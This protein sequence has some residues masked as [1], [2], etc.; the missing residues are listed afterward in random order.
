MK[1]A[2][3]GAGPMAKIFAEKAKN[4]DIETHCF[5]WE[6]GAEAK[7]IVDFFYPISIFEKE[8]IL[9]IC[10]ELKIDG[11]IATTE[12]TISIAAFIARNLKLNT[13]CQNV[14]ENITNKFWVR[15]RAKKA[16]GICQPHYKY[17]TADNDDYSGILFPSV[18]KPVTEGGKRG[19]T[20]ANNPEEYLSALQYAR[21]ADRKS[22]GLIAEEYLA[23]GNE[24]SVES[25]SFHGI[26][27]VIQI[28]QK[29]SSGPPHFV[30]LGHS[31]PACITTATKKHIIT[32]ISNLL[33]AVS[34]ENGPS[35]TEI[36]IIEDDI[37]LIE[38][39]ARPGGDHI[40]Y[41]LTELST[42]Y[43]YI[44]AIILVAMNV[45]PSLPKNGSYKYSGVRF[46][47]Q[48]TKNWLALFEN[49]DNE[50]W[51]YKKFAESDLSEL[52]YNDGYNTNYFIYCSDKY[53]DFLE[54]TDHAD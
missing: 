27:Q 25:L 26:H 10:R 2:I 33:D 29:I 30:E 54:I 46:I 24:Y 49:C 28:T 37:F 8:K 52:T 11:V 53:P 22:N 45:E 35:H 41:P 44:K 13:N 1:I 32:A 6:K 3:I 42:G 16:K 15:E 31:Q 50:D 43:D 36:K 7:D 48:Q 18:I 40:A 12:L 23:G 20:I 21:T 14:A 19:V 51:L 17:V 4:E 38:L 39:N 5:A 34:I 47:T 9:D